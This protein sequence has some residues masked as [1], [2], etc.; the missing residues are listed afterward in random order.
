M[1]T[2]C[3]SLTKAPELPATT[4]AASC[5]FHM[6]VGCTSLTKAPELPAT[7]LA[8][9]C[10]SAMFYR[11]TSLTQAPE[12][13][14]TTLANSCYSSMFSECTSLTQAPELPATTLPD[15]CYGSM[16]Y[17]CKK[18]NYIKMMAININVSMNY[19]FES[20]VYGVSTT[21]I[22]VMNAATTLTPS[23][24]SPGGWTVI[25]YNTDSNKYYLDKKCTKECDDHGNS[26]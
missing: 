4:L 17:K 25:Y 9:A 5:Y 7:T 23:P 24:S 13:P 2:G 18:L 6:F 14:A 12:L 3:T 10:Y 26:L 16:F 11:C 8:V 1:F 20:W 22:Y 15:N 19:P 21:G